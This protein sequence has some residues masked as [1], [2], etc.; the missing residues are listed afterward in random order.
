MPFCNNAFRTYI[1]RYKKNKQCMTNAI[2]RILGICSLMLLL[3]ACSHSRQPMAVDDMD[4][5]NG[6]EDTPVDIIVSRS[7]FTDAG[8]GETDTKFTPGCHIGV[9]V[10]GSAEYGNVQY[11]YPDNGSALVAVGEKIYCRAQSTLAVKAYY[12][13][14]NDGNYSAASVEADQS[15]GDNYYKSDALEAEGTISNGTLNLQFGHRMTKVILTFNEDVSDVTILNQSLSTSATTGIASIKAYG[16]TARKWKACIVPGQ[17]TLEVTGEKGGKDFAVTFN[18]GS[19]M[20]AG[21]QYSYTI[22]L[23]TRKDLSGGSVSISDNGSYYIKQTAES[24][25]NG[26]TISGSPTVYIEDLNVTSGRAIN[27]AGGTPTIIVMGNNTLRSTNFGESAIQLTN[28]NVVIKGSG[29]LTVIGADHGVGIGTIYAKDARCNIT[30]EDCTVVAIASNG[31]NE[32]DAAGIG[33]RGMA[34]CGNITIKNAHITS[35]GANGGAGIGSGWGSGARCGNIDI[36]LR[37]DDTKD[38]FLDRITA[39]SG[40]AKVGAGAEAACGTITWKTADGSVIP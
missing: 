17:T 39:G 40:A 26:I 9:A 23:I 12:P 1:L 5:A 7:T 3:A 28:G 38:A 34:Q 14:R 16:E 22:S 29:S 31:Q 4:D 35:K 8:N 18:A 21:S 6:G 10:A 19:A 24:S 32:S 37:A 36:T 2:Y 15:T 25:S 27:I 20:L 33:S 30:I 13:Y 11:K